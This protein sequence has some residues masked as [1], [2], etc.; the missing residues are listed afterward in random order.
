MKILAVAL[1]ASLLTIMPVVAT[2]EDYPCQPTSREG[3]VTACNGYDS[4]RGKNYICAIVNFPLANGRFIESISCIP[5]NT[6]SGGDIDVCSGL[7]LGAQN[8]GYTCMD[9]LGLPQTGVVPEF[10]DEDG[11]YVPD[12]LEGQICGRQ[13]VRNQVNNPTVPLRCRSSSDVQNELISPGELINGLYRLVLETID[14]YMPNVDRDGDNVPD[15]L[16]P[17]ICSLED[18]NSGVDGS[19]TGD[20]YKP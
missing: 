3:S 17:T 15:A 18:Q 1:V 16:E 9:N 14:Q 8:F 13:A 5:Q 11:D 12:L 7:I 20:D 4:D 2:G 19:C 6:I 10:I